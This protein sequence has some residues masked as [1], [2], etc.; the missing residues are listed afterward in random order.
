MR[1]FAACSCCP[2]LPPSFPLFFCCS[3]RCFVSLLRDVFGVDRGQLC[4]ASLRFPV[5]P[6][7]FVVP[8]LLCSS[9]V[10]SLREKICVVTA[11]RSKGSGP[12]SMPPCF[13][14]F[15]FCSRC[16]FCAALLPGFGPDRVRARYIHNT[17]AGCQAPGSPGGTPPAFPLFVRCSMRFF[18]LFPC[19]LI[20]VC[21]A[22]QGLLVVSG[23]E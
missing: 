5:L 4:P 21:A 2:V 7:W 23:K 8:V 18:S 11:G 3:S 1:R 19:A 10:R 16:G 22:L 9:R 15:A 20:F 17:A 6:P 12:G 14:L 13:L